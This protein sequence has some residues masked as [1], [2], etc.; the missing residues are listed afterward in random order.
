MTPI[1]AVLCDH[2]ACC[3]RRGPLCQA[4]WEVGADRLIFMLEARPKV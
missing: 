3:V 2:M 4:G 1:E